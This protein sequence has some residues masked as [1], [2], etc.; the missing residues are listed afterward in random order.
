MSR[1][2]SPFRVRAR[3]PSSKSTALTSL[4]VAF[5]ERVFA[6]INV[7]MTDVCRPDPPPHTNYIAVKFDFQLGLR[8]RNVVDT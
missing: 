2:S 1:Q 5:L 3:L 6:F 4:S 8:L 7:Y